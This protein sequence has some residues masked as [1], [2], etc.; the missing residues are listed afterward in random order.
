MKASAL[1][2]QDMPMDPYCPWGRHART[3]MNVHR[4]MLLLVAGHICTTLSACAGLCAYSSYSKTA[5]A[6][7][8]PHDSMSPLMVAKSWCVY[9]PPKNCRRYAAR[10]NGPSPSLKKPEYFSQPGKQIRLMQHPKYRSA[11]ALEI[12]DKIHVLHCV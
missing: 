8:L 4:N 10:S 6:T 1:K 11:D 9:Y 7:V 3:F 5:F 2:V 12:A